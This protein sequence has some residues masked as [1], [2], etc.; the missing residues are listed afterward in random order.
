MV[1][2]NRK[3]KSFELLNKAY[4][5][6]KEQKNQGNFIV[7]FF[8]KC[9]CTRYYLPKG[10]EI[11]L[12]KELEGPRHYIKDR[13]ITDIK[14]SFPKPINKKEASDYLI[15]YFD[16]KKIDGAA[17]SFGIPTD[18]PIN[19]EAFAYAIVEQFNRYFESDDEDISDNVY[20]E[21]LR[22]SVM[23]TEQVEVV[24]KSRGTL[25]AGDSAF[26]PPQSNKKQHNTV[27]YSNFLHTWVIKNNGRV[28][29][30]GRKLKLINQSDIRPR[31]NQKEIPIP[32][33][34]PLN[35]AVVTVEIQARGFEGAYEMK[36]IME[37]FQ[38][39][40]CFEGFPYLF[41]FTVIS[42]YEHKGLESEN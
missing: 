40:N 35:Q 28:N 42:R 37:N 14:D 22:F 15:A 9:G 7:C 16:D 11:P 18:N 41:N 32:E 27:C 3:I 38:G 5:A 6:L 26:L 23:P 1:G 10:D 13:S 30:S 4:K 39:Q 20:Q 19:K 21:Y 25:V 17:N 8:I 12:T 34:A 24:L 2:R 36:W 31:A 29:W 33:T